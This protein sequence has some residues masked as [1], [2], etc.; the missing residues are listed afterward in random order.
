MRLCSW[1]QTLSPLPFP[2][3]RNW[4]R[5]TLSTVEPGPCLSSSE[6][7]YWWGCAVEDRHLSASPKRS[8]SSST[9]SPKRSSPS[10]RKKIRIC[11]SP[12]FPFYILV[13]HI[14]EYVS[15]IFSNVE[16]FAHKAPVAFNCGLRFNGSIILTRLQ[17]VEK[18]I[19]LL[20]N[21]LEIIH[22]EMILCSCL[23]CDN[24]QN[25]V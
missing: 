25:H 4:P 24:H 8:S 5:L 17:S 18:S 20:P 23:Y 12:P 7:L 3:E 13:N 22:Y 2:E 9:T 10:R 21:D 6:L 14:S 19:K 16:S 15:L 11:S 1:R